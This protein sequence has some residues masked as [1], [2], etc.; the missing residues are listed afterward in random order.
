MFDDEL[1][2]QV[3]TEFE[4]LWNLHQ[5]VESEAKRAAFA[6]AFAHYLTTLG[7][8]WDEWEDNLSDRLDLK[9]M[10]LCKGIQL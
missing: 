1:H 7:K 9:D 6:E 5:P 8:T 2:E 3:S 10:V 4:R